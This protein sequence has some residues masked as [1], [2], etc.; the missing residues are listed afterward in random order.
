MYA[1]EKV[2]PEESGRADRELAIK[3]NN[4]HKPGTSINNPL[5][6]NGGNNSEPN[7]VEERRNGTHG[8]LR[9]FGAFSSILL[10]V[11]SNQH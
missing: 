10:V 7:E 11:T 8:C 2:G 3:V 5:A 1:S 6:F 4:Y 9:C